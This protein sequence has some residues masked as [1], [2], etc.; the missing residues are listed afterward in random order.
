MENRDIRGVSVTN[1]G[2]FVPGGGRPG[3]GYEF[4][5]KIANGAVLRENE[6]DV[7]LVCRKANLGET[8]IGRSERSLPLAITQ[9]LFHS[10]RLVYSFVPGA[11]TRVILPEN[12]A[13]TNAFGR[14][15]IGY[16]RA[17]DG[18]VEVAIELRLPPQ[19]VAPAD[20]PA[21]AEF[22]STVDAWEK[23]E[24]VLRNR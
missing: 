15:S 24:I 7:P 2:F 23:E 21:F 9:P 8:Y 17:P 3:Y 14:Y 11:A 1:I 5:A 4:G 20:Y 10:Q 22:C 13:V 12:R 19:T 6:I 18:S 16:G